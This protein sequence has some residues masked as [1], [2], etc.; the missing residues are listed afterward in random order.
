MAGATLSGRLFDVSS[1]RSPST[2]AETLKLVTRTV[3]SLAD[4]YGPGRIEGVGVSIHGIVNSWTGTVE[5]GNLPD[6]LRV[7][8]QD[9]LQKSLGM[10]VQVEP[11]ACGDR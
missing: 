2:S 3:R 1:I 10:P 11:P 4:K 6:W 8:V 5:L 9:C 7:P